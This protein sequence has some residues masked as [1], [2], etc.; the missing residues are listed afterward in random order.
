MT[1]GTK[2]QLR[3]LVLDDD[4]GWTCANGFEV[5]DIGV[6]FMGSLKVG[7][8]DF[9]DQ[10]LGGWNVVRGGIGHGGLDGS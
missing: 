3:L 6:E 10:L 4:E 8:K 2:V 9:Q 7:G 1:V 5:K